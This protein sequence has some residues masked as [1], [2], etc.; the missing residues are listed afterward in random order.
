MDPNNQ[1]Q[2][3]PTQA[4]QGVPIQP[5]PAAAA[6]QV[7]SS[8][9]DPM[10]KKPNDPLKIAS[11]VALIVVITSLVAGIVFFDSIKSLLTNK[12]AGKDGDANTQSVFPTI[13]PKVVCARFT[14]INHALQNADKAC[15]L[16][17]S[18]QNLS[19]L[20]DLTKLTKLT[21]VVLKDNKFAEFPPQLIGLSNLIELDI[22]NN[23]IKTIPDSIKNLKKLNII[24]LTGND[25]ISNSSEIEKLA[26]ITVI[27]A[28]NPE[29]NFEETEPP[30]ENPVIESES[31][32][33]RPD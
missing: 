4:S 15:I 1:V 7:Y 30:A 17:L 29:D 6:P 13:D 27:G 5:Q 21:T 26:G 24:N 10:S 19:S 18:G 16:D 20:P 11:I 23:Q 9:Q 22:S 33:F 8:Q 3:Q 14:N 31:V 32:N 25:V 12:G 28:V 2:A